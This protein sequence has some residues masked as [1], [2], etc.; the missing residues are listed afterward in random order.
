[1]VL[2]TVAALLYFGARMV[3]KSADSLAFANAQDLLVGD[4]ALGGE[5]IELPGGQLGAQV[6]EQGVDV[7][8]AFGIGGYPQQTVSLDRPR[9]HTPKV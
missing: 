1:M 6:A 5:L 7:E 2:I 9:S 4:T 8:L 3:T